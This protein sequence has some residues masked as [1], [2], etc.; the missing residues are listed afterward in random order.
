M[1]GNPRGARLEVSWDT[2]ELDATCASWSDQYDL[3]GHLTQCVANQ[4]KER[5]ETQIDPKGVPWKAWHPAYAKTVK[6]PNA[7][8][9]RQSGALQRSIASQA[10]GPKVGIVGTKLA[11]A[12]QHQYGGKTDRGWHVPA[13]PFLGISESDR[14]ELRELAKSWMKERVR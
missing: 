3:M 11:Y 9:L 1:K 8:I 14:E 7:S 4:N 5:F 10:F 2:V 6:N 12:K 13:R